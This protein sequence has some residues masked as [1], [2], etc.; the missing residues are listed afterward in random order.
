MH[1][2]QV[3]NFGPLTDVDISLQ[4]INFFLGEQASGKSTLA[5]LIYFFRTLPD[6]LSNRLLVSRFDDWKDFSKSFI[7]ILKKKF[8]N[9]FGKTKELGDFYIKYEFT[10]HVAIEIQPDKVYLD[11]KFCGDLMRQMN[12]IWERVCNAFSQ[13]KNAPHSIYTNLGPDIYNQVQNLYDNNFFHVYIPA[14]RAFLSHQMLLNLI[15]AE[16]LIGIAPDGAVTRFDLIDAPTRNYIA[17]VSRIRDY[18][19]R[20]QTETRPEEE[21]TNTA[22]TYLLSLTQKILK[23]AYIPDKDNDYI[24]VAGNGRVRLAYASSGQQE[25]L[26]ILNLL[27][28][29]TAQ[30]R[31]CLVIIEEPEAHLYPEAQYMLVKA[32]AAF[33]N[34][35]GSQIIITTH[36]PY[37]LSSFNNLIFAGKIGSNLADDDKLKAIIPQKS[38]L[39][40]TEFSSYLL[41]AGGARDIKDEKLT[42]IDISELDAV[43]SRQDSEYEEMLALWSRTR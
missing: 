4:K 16:E 24:E 15:L 31:K 14:G 11:I 18:Y 2:I 30:K 43:A 17:E 3:K 19:L 6:E 40:P 12:Q 21:N 36:S 27:N 8:T 39:E 38:W 32:I 37:I 25:V 5:K 22:S 33:A 13:D 1:R 23:G 34:D 42:M 41:E 10:T 20:S 9:I 7:S 28:T 35:T 29:Y 26:W